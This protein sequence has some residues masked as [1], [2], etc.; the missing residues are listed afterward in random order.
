[1]EWLK[2]GITRIQKNRDH[3]PNIWKKGENLMTQSINIVVNLDSMKMGESGA[4][5]GG[6]FLIHQMDF[7][8]KKIGAISLLL[9]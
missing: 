5:T 8:Q 6:I 1:M 3:I 9:F 4:I 7:S 2:C